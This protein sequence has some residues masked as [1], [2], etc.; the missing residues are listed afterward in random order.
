[1]RIEFTMGTDMDLAS[2][3]V[4]DRLDRVR[5]QLPDDVERIFIRRWQTS[6]I[7]VLR[8]SLA[9]KG[10]NDELYEIVNKVVVPK[11]QRVE[12]V[13]NVEVGGIDERVVQVNLD[14]ERMRAHNLD[15]FRLA[16]SLRNNNINI[17]G[18][19]IMDAGRKFNVRTIGEF[20]TIEEIAQVPIAGTHLV[21][22][23][24]ATIKLDFPEKKRFQHLNKRDA[25][26]ISVYKASTAN[27]VDVARSVRQVLTTLRQDPKYAGLQMQVFRDQSKAIL[28]SLNSLTM[29]GLLGGGLATLMLF[30]FLRKVRSK[31]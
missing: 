28:D 12:G 19:T 21:L 22:G 2:V 7:P 1:M 15:F 26:V 10:T 27:V 20:R 6:D 25:I 17:A 24:V 30:V 14:L 5:P 8:F 11:I 13:A 9:Y 23:D 31:C 29:A 16:R 4:R 3:E 18:G